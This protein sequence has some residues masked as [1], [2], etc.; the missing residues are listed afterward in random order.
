MET[1]SQFQFDPSLLTLA[2][3][4]ERTAAAAFAKIE[5]VERRNAEKVLGAFIRHGV[6][7]AHLQGSTG[8]G[9]GDRGRDTLDEIYAEA[10]GC[11]DALVRSSLASGTHALAV[12]L[13]GALRPGDLLLSL[14]G[15]P[16]DT[17]EEVI[18]LRGEGAGSL[19]DFGVRYD[20]VALRNGKIDLPA[21]LEK[22]AG[23]K[24][25]YVQRSRGYSLRPTLSVT[26][27]GEAARALKAKY[28]DL[29]VMVDNCYGEFVEEREPTD[30]GA[31][32][33]IGS[34][35]KN[36]GGAIA[37]TGGYIAGRRDLVELCSYRLTTPGTGK[38]I[39]CTLDELRNLYLGFFLAPTVVASALKTAVF[40]AALF[41]QLGYKAYPSA[42]EERHDIIQALCLE[43]PQALTAFCEGIQSGSPVDSMA[44][45]EPWDM[46]GYD[47]Q[48][49]MAAGTFTLGAS[50]E[51]SADAPMREP[52]AV[53]MQGG[54]TYPTARIGILLAAQRLVK[55]LGRTL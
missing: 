49:I 45:P 27:I 14:T 39:G 53:W 43:T 15:K 34:L 8:Y 13:F 18:G 38:E 40:A 41:E 2:E 35:I 3:N 37:R 28:P 42:L 19:R 30:V 52:F 17:L 9:Y 29:I 55:K 25:C 47:S 50:I 11:E 48:V 16:Y 24:V 20:E 44:T 23:A 46:P 1:N 51:L 31:D 6:S 7:A 54:I 5:A 33:I 22:A 36:P 10:F 32:L 4:A 12:A 26:E 21:A